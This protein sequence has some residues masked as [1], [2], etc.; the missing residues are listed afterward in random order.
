MARWSASDPLE[1][2]YAPW[3]SYNYC[4]NNPLKF[5]DPTG[6]GVE[7]SKPKEETVD[8]V[9]TRYVDV[10]STVYIYTAD[11]GLDASQYENAIEK[12]LND[13]FNNKD[14]NGVP[15]Y[16]TAFDEETGGKL[17]LRFKIDV[18]ALASP[19]AAKEELARL[20]ET[21]KGYS[22]AGYNFFYLTN[23]PGVDVNGYGIGGS[24]LLLANP[25][26]VHHYSHE[27]AHQMNWSIPLVDDRFADHA[28]AT[29]GRNA[30]GQIETNISDRVPDKE[31]FMATLTNSI[32]TGGF[33]NSRRHVTQY[34]ID[35]LNY[36]RTLINGYNDVM[37]KRGNYTIGQ[38]WPEIFDNY[39]QALSGYNS[40]LDKQTEF[41]R[42]LILR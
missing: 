14:E 10:T 11:A 21:E 40:L 22:R 16:F 18:I 1:A 26:G 17:Q 25:I 20:R 32:M 33:G 34:D 6:E 3:S 28:T 13:Q 8:G 38:D 23:N 35:K 2:K 31:F 29:Y 24:G 30:A 4:E 19:Q 27:F 9:T 7:I 12:D 42:Q 15:R 39:Q 41:Q 36:G 37:S 5:I